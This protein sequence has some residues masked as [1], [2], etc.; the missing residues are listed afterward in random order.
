MANYWKQDII[1]E[2]LPVWTMKEERRVLCGQL[3]DPAVFI[4]LYIHRLL[5]RR[6]LEGDLTV[7]GN[8]QIEI[9]VSKSE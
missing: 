1:S 9:K 7:P 2:F 8:Y 6:E 4:P 5:I 3:M